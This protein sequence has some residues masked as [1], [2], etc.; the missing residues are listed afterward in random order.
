M[1]LYFNLL[2]GTI[3]QCGKRHT[4][5]SAM[6]REHNTTILRQL[7]DLTNCLSGM[8]QTCP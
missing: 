5:V 3:P 1:G 7:C 8:I 4:V 2:F 6:I